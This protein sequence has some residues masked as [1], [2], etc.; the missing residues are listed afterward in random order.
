MLITN[1]T[2][3]WIQSYHNHIDIPEWNVIEIL[4]LL[5][6]EWK[7]WSKW[8]AI[9][10]SI[11]EEKFSQS[12][13]VGLS[14][15]FVVTLNWNFS[16]IRFYLFSCHFNS[17]ATFYFSSPSYFESLALN[18]MLL[19]TAFLLFNDTCTKYPEQQRLFEFWAMTV[20]PCICVWNEMTLCSRCGT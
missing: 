5:L 19:C 17:T 18:K 14:F 7:I 16:F 4:F 15:S 12:N 13:L 10:I 1:K 8:E 2:Q 20:C 3:K 6:F 9:C 11:R